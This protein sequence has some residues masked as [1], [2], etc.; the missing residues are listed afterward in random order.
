M[1]LLLN[2]SHFLACCRRSRSWGFF[3][4]EKLKFV[5]CVRK[6]VQ[7]FTGTGRNVVNQGI[8]IMGPGMNLASVGNRILVVMVQKLNLGKQSQSPYVGG[9][10]QSRLLQVSFG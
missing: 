3:G 2:G 5:H 9:I 8:R 1:Q 6:A 4:Q 10:S 7:P